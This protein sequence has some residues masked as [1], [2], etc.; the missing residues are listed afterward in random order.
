MDMKAC[1][2]MA[3]N[4]LT[5]SDYETNFDAEEKLTPKMKEFCVE[6]LKTVDE[7]L[8]DTVKKYWNK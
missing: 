7:E 8:Y 3:L 6:Y 5:L 1:Q 2:I 4:T